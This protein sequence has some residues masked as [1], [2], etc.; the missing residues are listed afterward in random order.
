VE[1]QNFGPKSVES[2]RGTGGGERG[3]GEEGEKVKKESHSK[4]RGIPQNLKQV[5]TGENPKVWISRKNKQKTMVKN[6]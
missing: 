4:G 2:I 3:K 5:G 6:I 1:L